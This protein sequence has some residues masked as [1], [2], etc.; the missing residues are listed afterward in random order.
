M[1][2]PGPVARRAVEVAEGYRG[3]L[4]SGGNNRGHAVEDFLRSVD[5]PPGQPWCAAFV[6]HCL[7]TAAEQLRR[8][9]P[10]WVPDSGWTPA[11]KVAAVA[12][13]RWLSISEAIGARVSA[14]G[15]PM[16]GDL[17]CFYFPAKGRIAHIGIVTKAEQGSGCVWSVEG[18]TGPD[19]GEVRRDGDGVWQKR[20]PWSSLGVAG[21][22]VRLDF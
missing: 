13:G 2:E 20:R 16:R 17:V 1:T 21:G 18:N 5:L 22:F 7:E 19:D 14:L 12:N 8:K 3:T 9:I 10:A 11:Y 4:E 6:R 15:R